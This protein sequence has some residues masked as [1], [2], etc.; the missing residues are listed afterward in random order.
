MLTEVY[1]LRFPLYFLK[2]QGF[3]RECNSCSTEELVQPSITV[4]RISKGNTDH[5]YSVK[6]N[7]FSSTNADYIFFYMTSPL[8][9]VS[10]L[11]RIKTNKG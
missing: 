6:D 11:Y 4:C 7:Y 10:N 2:I 1:V 3:F 8:E 5:R 9:S